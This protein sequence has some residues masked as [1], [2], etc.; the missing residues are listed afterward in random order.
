LPDC[1]KEYAVGFL[2]TK[3][4]QMKRKLYLMSFGFGAMILAANDVSAQTRNCADHAQI[5][6]RLATSYGESRQSVGLSSDNAMVEIFASA[7]TGS[8]TIVVTRP[9]GPSCL[10]AAGQSFQQVADA[11]PNLDRGT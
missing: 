8:W 5:V 11:V 6:E 4:N 2:T 7:E 10:I 3:V 9:D 1:N